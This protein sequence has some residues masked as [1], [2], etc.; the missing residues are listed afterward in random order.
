MS[1]IST[2][3]HFEGSFEYSVRTS[4]AG[5][6]GRL[7]DHMPLAQD[8]W[9]GWPVDESQLSAARRGDGLP[10]TIATRTSFC[11]ASGIAPVV[12]T[13]ISF[14]IGIKIKQAPSPFF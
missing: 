1:W 10:F 8:R 3:V 11:K 13:Y 14:F 6:G 12:V 5:I 4:E 9:R 2:I 7:M